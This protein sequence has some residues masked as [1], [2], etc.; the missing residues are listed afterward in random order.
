MKR[1]IDRADVYDIAYQWKDYTVEAAAIDRLIRKHG[2]PAGRDLL[3]VACGTGKHAA[4]LQ[5]L[6]WDCT[7][8]DIDAGSLAFAR[9]R[10]PAARFIR[11]DMRTMRLGKSFDVITCLFSSIAYLGTTGE[12]RDTL[13]SFA[14]HLK[15]H[16]VVLVEPWW[17]RELWTDSTHLS[18]AERGPLKVARGS[19]SR[20]RSG[21][22]I[23]DIRY[24]A[25]DEERKVGETFTEHL[26]LT[27]FPVDAFRRA[28]EQAGLLHTFIP[29][30]VLTPQDPGRGLHAGRWA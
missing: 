8:T 24:I 4:E 10:L 21:R 19:I 23:F 14:R 12:L 5:G 30:P 1:S 16:G 9:R 3:D 17:T 13:R 6:G 18:I 20:R 7:G 22:S 29:G 25:L 15:P 26:V 11:A 27:M 28:F 2:P